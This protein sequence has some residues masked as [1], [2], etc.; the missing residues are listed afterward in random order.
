[1][2]KADCEHEGILIASYD[3]YA[4]SAF[5]E[6]IDVELTVELD[7]RGYIRLIEDGDRNCIDHNEKFK[8]NYCPICGEE[9]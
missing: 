5:N 1:V 8:I 4:P 3:F 7:S 9:F 6:K 2:R